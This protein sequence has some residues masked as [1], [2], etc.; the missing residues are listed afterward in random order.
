MTQPKRRK[1]GRTPPMSAL[2]GNDDNQ[3]PDDIVWD[4]DNPP[5]VHFCTMNDEHHASDCDGNCGEK[6]ITELDVKLHNEHLAWA[7]A[8]MHPLMVPVGFDALGVPGMP[9]D[10]FDTEAKLHGI[11]NALMNAGILTEEEMDLQYKQAKFDKMNKVRILNE[12][13]VKSARAAAMLGIRKPGLL[14]PHGEKLG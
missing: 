9:I 10:L 13:A 8:G 7:R 6:P 5:T 2:N 1:K 14:G 4:E 3:F 12:E 11:L